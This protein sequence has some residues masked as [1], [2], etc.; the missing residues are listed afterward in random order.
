MICKS[1]PASTA[2]LGTLNETSTGDGL[3]VVNT[4]VAYTRRIIEN[5]FFVLLISKIY[6]LR[7]NKNMI[8]KC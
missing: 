6:N 4:N 8:I 3:K 7:N 1:Q 2:L 5:F